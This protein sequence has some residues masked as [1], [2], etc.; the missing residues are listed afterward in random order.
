MERP[1]TVRKFKGFSKKGDYGYTYLLTG[2]K[3]PKYDPRPEA[4]G[5]LDEANSALG[6]VRATVQDDMVKRIVRRVQQDLFVMGAQVATPPDKR[7]VLQCVIGEGHVQRLEEDIA[8]LLEKT[9]FPDRFIIPGS[10]LESASLDLARAVVRRAERLIHYLIHKKLLKDTN[11][12][13]YLNRLGDLLFT[14]A[15]YVDYGKKGGYELFILSEYVKENPS[16]VKGS[17]RK[18]AKAPLQ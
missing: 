16:D 5:T 17:K 8:F 6:L 18:P 4:Y 15:R 3:V 11:L 7:G 12:E 9:P 13:R 2:D 14:L 1:V 10:T